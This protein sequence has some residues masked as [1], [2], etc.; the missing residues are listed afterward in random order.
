MPRIEFYVLSS[1]DTTGRLRAACQLAF[2]AWSAGM[3]VFV[4]GS[5]AAQ[6]SELDELLWTFKAERFV[7][8]DLHQEAPL[9]PVV[10]GVDDA[11]SAEQGVLINLGS[12][13]SPHVERFSRI[14]E[15][16]N[17]QPELLNACRENFRTYRQRGYD[18]QRVEL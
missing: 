10:V 14:I 13:L 3:P 16:V 7:P 9:S 2:K 18:P 1:S 11:P 6:C 4:R 17:R 8:H 5:D 15:I 12:S